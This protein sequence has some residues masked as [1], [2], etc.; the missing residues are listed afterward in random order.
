MIPAF[1][2]PNHDSEGLIV[3]SEPII[4]YEKLEWF[5]KFLI[6]IVKII[7]IAFNLMFIHIELHLP[8]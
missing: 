2:T 4:F 7:I 8:F 6:R 5:L 3:S 1:V